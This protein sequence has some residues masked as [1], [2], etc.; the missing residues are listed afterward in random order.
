[1]KPN[2]VVIDQVGNPIVKPSVKKKTN[3]NPKSAR[4]SKGRP[5]GLTEEIKTQL[6]NAIKVGAYQEHAAAF[7]G[8]SRGTYF[9]WMQRGY[10]ERLRLDED[11]M[12]EPNEGE[13]RYLDLFDAVSQARGLAAVRNVENVAKAANNGDWRASAWWLERSFPKIWGRDLGG[14]EVTEIDVSAI[15]VEVSIERLEVI[16]MKAIEARKPKE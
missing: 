9:L 13:A 16:A 1:M 10:A 14:I 6:V 2:T 7:V 12:T 4:T 11:L 15:K 5:S 3:H 8:V